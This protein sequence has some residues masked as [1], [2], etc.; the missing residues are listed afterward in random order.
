MQRAEGRASFWPALETVVQRGLYESIAT[1]GEI[2]KYE[3]Y[4]LSKGTDNIAPVSSKIALRQ[5]GALAW[6]QEHSPES[7]NGLQRRCNGSG[8]P[9]CV[10]NIEETWNPAMGTAS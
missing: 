3:D 9:I 7:S 6:E 2:R 5:A 4:V 10:S 1:Y 8:L